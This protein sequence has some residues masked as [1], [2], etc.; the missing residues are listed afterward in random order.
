[1]LVEWKNTYNSFECIHKFQN[2]VLHRKFNSERCNNVQML[3]Q[4]SLRECRSR[5]VKQGFYYP[6]VVC[7]IIAGF[8]RELI[9]RSR[10]RLVSVWVSL[11]NLSQRETQL[12][13]ETRWQ[14]NRRNNQDGKQHVKRERK[15][16]E[17]NLSH[18]MHFNTQQ[19][20]LQWKPITTTKK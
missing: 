6:A 4:C 1:M 8:L 13:R 14:G 12:T 3:K 9:F 11:E 17:R 15:Y 18:K 5:H 19:K 20:N 2:I 16:N 10:M 7:I